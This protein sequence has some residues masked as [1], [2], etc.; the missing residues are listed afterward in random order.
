VIPS[1]LKILRLSIKIKNVRHA[2]GSSSNRNVVKPIVIGMGVSILASLFLLVYYNINPNNNNNNPY[3]SK[4]YGFT[5]NHPAGWSIEENYPFVTAAGDGY[6]AVVV[7]YNG[8]GNFIVQVRPMQNN[9]KLDRF[10]S[11]QLVTIASSKN[12]TQTDMKI[13]E[14]EFTTVSSRPAGFVTFTVADQGHTWKERLLYTKNDRQ[15]YTIV[16][17]AA[18]EDQL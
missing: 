18:L 14:Q 7:F 3:V 4:Q 17:T 1:S 8:Q 16:T 13:Q 10:V 9:Q 11:D 12:S 5:M 15:F 2:K 6:D